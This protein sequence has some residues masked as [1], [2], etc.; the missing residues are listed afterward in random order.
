[1]IH[2]NFMCQSHSQ[3]TRHLI[4]ALI[5][6]ICCC[7][8]ARGMNDEKVQP[9]EVNTTD[10]LAFAKAEGTFQQARVM[11]ARKPEEAVNL[12]EV[13]LDFCGTNPALRPLKAI[14]HDYCA[15][16]LWEKLKRYD[17][18]EEHYK[19]ALNLDPKNAGIHYNLAVCYGTQERYAL[20]ERLFFKAVELDIG[21]IFYQAMYAKF[22]RHLGALKSEKYSRIKLARRHNDYAILL[23]EVGQYEEAEEQYNLAVVVD[24]YLLQPRYNVALLL[25]ELGRPNDALVH[26]QEALK[27]KLLDEER[28]I[29]LKV[30]AELQAELADA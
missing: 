15:S 22:L 14:A 16:L 10:R 27:L 26:I 12:Y 20:A 29:L 7:T 6:T 28:S 19:L 23:K 5:F 11:A 9:E 21:N 4:R 1:M 18:A 3:V 17:D 2:Q 25:R 8:L 30:E 24:G 13:V